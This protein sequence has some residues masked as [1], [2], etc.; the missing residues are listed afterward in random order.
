MNESVSTLAVFAT[1]LLPL[2]V[3]SFTVWLAVFLTRTPKCKSNLLK[4]VGPF[5]FVLANALFLTFNIS[6]QNGPWGAI[7][8]WP[9]FWTYIFLPTSLIYSLNF[10]SWLDQRSR[11]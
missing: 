2:A 8:T 10:Y 4:Y 5:T 6:L 11:A 3:S 7:N 9:N 1:L